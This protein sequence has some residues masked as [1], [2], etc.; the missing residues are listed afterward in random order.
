MIDTRDMWITVKWMFGVILFSTL[1]VGIIIGLFTGIK[2]AQQDNSIPNEVVGKLESGSP[3]HSIPTNTMIVAACTDNSGV[4][5]YIVKDKNGNH[6][7]V[8]LTSRIIWKIEEV[9]VKS[10]TCVSNKEK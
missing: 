9:N 10:P 3:K 8:G 1:L 5:A 6:Y 2:K 7:Y 4:F